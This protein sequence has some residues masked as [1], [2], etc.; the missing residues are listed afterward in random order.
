MTPEMQAIHGLVG[1]LERRY[2]LLPGTDEDLIS[3][4]TLTLYRLE[5]KTVGYRIAAARNAVLHEMR[6]YLPRGYK[7]G[8]VSHLKRPDDIP[9]T[10]YFDDVKQEPH[11]R[12]EERGFSFFDEEKILTLL[13]DLPQFQ[14]IVVEMR[15]GLNGADPHDND[16]PRGWLRIASR[17]GATVCQTKNAFE[18][19]IETMRERLALNG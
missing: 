5:G 12:C 2:R 14:R 3:V 11:R 13:D 17:L 8:S 1:K 15:F 6:K 7:C 10:V 4:A 19:A 16:G 18:E 9:I